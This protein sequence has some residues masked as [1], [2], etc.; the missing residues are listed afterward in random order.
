M[1]I[2]L[3]KRFIKILYSKNHFSIYHIFYILKNKK[4]SKIIYFINLYIYFLGFLKS[5]NMIKIKNLRVIYY[6]L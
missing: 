4:L 5:N 6:F 1:H 3:N 2:K